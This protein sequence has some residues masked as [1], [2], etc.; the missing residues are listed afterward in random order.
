MAAA[1]KVECVRKQTQPF[2]R[3]KFNEIS[4][5]TIE[6]PDSSVRSE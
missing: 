6:L 3:R 5:A 2:G 4:V 1:R